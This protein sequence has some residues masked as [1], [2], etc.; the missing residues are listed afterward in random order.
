MAI[1][2]AQARECH[3]A[4]RASEPVFSVQARAMAKAEEFRLVAKKMT[5]IRQ[6]PMRMASFKGRVLN[7]A[8]IAG[9]MPCC[10]KMVAISA[11][12]CSWTCRE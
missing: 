3:A 10:W 11:T 8:V 7:T 4:G 2:I 9:K 5:E 6:N 12:P 1:I